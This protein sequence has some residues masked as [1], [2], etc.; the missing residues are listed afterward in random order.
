MSCICAARVALDVVE[1]RGRPLRR[2]VVPRRSM[3]VQPRTALSGVRSSCES[4][5]RNSS[6]TRLACSRSRINCA[7][8]S[9]SARSW[10][11]KLP[12][13]G[14]V[15]HRAGRKAR[16]AIIID[17]DAAAVL[18]PAD[19][20]VGADDAVIEAVFAARGDGGVD[21]AHDAIVVVGMDACEG[22]SRSGPSVSTASRPRMWFRLSSWVAMPLVRSTCH[23]PMPAAP[24]AFRSRCQASRT[25][26]D[27]MAGATQCTADAS[28]GCAPLERLGFGAFA[29]VQRLRSGAAHLLEALHGRPLGAHFALEDFGL[30]REIENGSVEGTVFRGRAIAT[31]FR[32]SGEERRL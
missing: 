4:M 9:E 10:S 11:S 18:E 28:A 14:D 6:L 3:R 19:L 2:H 5:A 21:G 22:R 31:S 26:C 12:P 8:S 1:D 20:A 23:V 16:R 13:R 27:G 15:H 29:D 30:L 25:S 32:L 24:R 17:D 7:R